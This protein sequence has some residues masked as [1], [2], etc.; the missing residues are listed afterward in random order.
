MYSFAFASRDDIVP[1]FTNPTIIIAI[2]HLLVL[3][4][5]TLGVKVRVKSVPT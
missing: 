5:P 2:G 4:V 1:S 3:A